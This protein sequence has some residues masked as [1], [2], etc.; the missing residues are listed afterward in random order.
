MFCWRLGR[1]LRLRSSGYRS[2]RR[3]VGLD[4]G[5]TVFWSSF[6][7]AMICAIVRGGTVDMIAVNC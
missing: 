3:E 1:L 4:R 6:R 5:Q 2:E 7:S